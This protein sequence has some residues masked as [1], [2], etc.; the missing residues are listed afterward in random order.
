M[1]DQV[2]DTRQE[3][4]GFAGAGDAWVM[5]IAQLVTA[6]SNARR[7]KEKPQLFARAPSKLAVGDAHGCIVIVD[8]LYPRRQARR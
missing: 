3:H 5:G 8:T 1:L 6:V 4:A 2:V 7:G